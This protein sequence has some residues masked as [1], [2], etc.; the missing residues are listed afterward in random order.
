M[1][2]LDRKINSQLRRVTK[3][4]CGDVTIA[5]LFPNAFIQEHTCG[6]YKS[7]RS[8]FC[9]SE[10]KITDEAA[11]SAMPDTVIDG[12]VSRNTNFKT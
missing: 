7:A 5:Q 2:K 4:L 6:K 1:D 10:L 3:G 11:F 8:F 12:F 9:T